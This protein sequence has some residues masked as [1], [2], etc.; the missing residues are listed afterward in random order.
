MARRST[1]QDLSQRSYFAKNDRPAAAG[2]LNFTGTARQITALVRAMD[3]GAYWNP[4]TCPKIATDS[5][6][7]LVGKAVAG[8]AAD[9][10]PG[11]VTDVTNDSLSCATDSS[12]CAQN[13]LGNLVCVIVYV[14]PAK[15]SIGP[16]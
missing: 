6:V 11:T 8:S 9:A 14:N 12:L 7:F 5:G 4:L 16:S 13:H 2:R 10:A 3:H 1:T 15:S